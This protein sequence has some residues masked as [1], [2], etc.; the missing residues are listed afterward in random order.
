MG[1][2]RRE[3]SEV[4]GGCSGRARQ[5]W[6]V[7][8]ALGVAP[9]QVRLVATSATIGGEID[10]QDRLR[11]FLAALASLPAAAVEVIERRSAKPSLPPPGPDLPLA[12]DALGGLDGADLW[13]WL[14][15]H[16][17]MYGR[18]PPG[19]NTPTPCAGSHWPGAARGSP[20][21]AP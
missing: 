14:A 17:R 2:A 1:D 21:P 3:R 8:A 13:Q 7:R 6:R 18:A 15:P 12:P 4:E 16:P 9:E 5:T 20:A 10:A 11:D 19:Q